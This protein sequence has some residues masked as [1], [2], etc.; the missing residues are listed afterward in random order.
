MKYTI[1]PRAVEIALWLVTCTLLAGGIG[2]ETNWGQSLNPK[3]PQVDY[4]HAQYVPPALI[5][6]PAIGSTIDHLEMVERPL[7]VFTRRPA[8]PGAQIAAPTMKKGQYKLVGVTIVGGKKIV[9]LTE[10]SSGKMR[11]VAEGSNVGEINVAS[12]QPDRV[13]LTQGNDEEFITLKV[14]P[15]T[16][17]AGT[18]KTPPPEPNVGTVPN[19]KQVPATPPPA[20]PSSKPTVPPPA[21]PT[22][23][24]QQTPSPQQ[25][26][27]PEGTTGKTASPVMDFDSVMRGI[28]IQRAKEE[29]LRAK[30]LADKQQA[31]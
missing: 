1:D 9:F 24:G 6:P 30:A 5:T 21:A 15:S 25:K 18:P 12:I 13:R 8:P 2:Y 7:F 28:A 23:A 19:N 14:E 3:L 31:K 16:P 4:E 11:T 27:A 26:Q 20:P 22:A 10:I 29:A 17:L